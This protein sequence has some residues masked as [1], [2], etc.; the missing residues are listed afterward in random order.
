VDIHGHPQKRYA[1]SPLTRG[2]LVKAESLRGLNPHLGPGGGFANEPRKGANPRRSQHAPFPHLNSFSGRAP[3]PIPADFK[4]KE[5][6]EIRRQCSGGET[7]WSEIRCSNRVPDR[8]KVFP[9]ALGSGLF[10]LVPPCPNGRRSV[11]P[12]GTPSSLVPSFGNASVR[13]PSCLSRRSPTPHCHRMLSHGGRRLCRRGR[14]A[15]GHVRP[16]R[17]AGPATAEYGR[18]FG[19]HGNALLNPVH[20]PFPPSMKPGYRARNWLARALKTNFPPERGS[21]TRISPRSPHV[22]SPQKQSGRPPV[23]G[24]FSRSSPFASWEETGPQQQPFFSK[25]ARRVSPGA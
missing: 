8:A 12:E 3:P 25:S 9:P 22:K 19:W 15:A 14:Q 11:V 17:M 5:R 16:D 1:Q 7:A 2:R 20:H 13:P 21:R 18:I 10:G 24:P 23:C 6:P 4:A